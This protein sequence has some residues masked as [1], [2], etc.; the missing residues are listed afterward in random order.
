MEVKNNYIF[1][2]YWMGNECGQRQCATNYGC[3]T[4]PLAINHS[5]L[6][7]VC[8]HYDNGES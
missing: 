5:V 1:D 7:T 6:I 2:L 3:P 8:S 4:L